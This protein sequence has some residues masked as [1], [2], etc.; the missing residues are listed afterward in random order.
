MQYK[1]CEE[2]QVSHP[3]SDG[4]LCVECQLAQAQTTSDNF[5]NELDT[6]LA[7]NVRY[8]QDDRQLIVEAVRDFKQARE[9]KKGV[10]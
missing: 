7:N 6:W 2:C 8:T 1:L 5:D 4:D 9:L 3:V 10:R